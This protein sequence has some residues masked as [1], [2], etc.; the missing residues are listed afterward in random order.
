VPFT[1]L[2]ISVEV[3][4]VGDVKLPDYKKLKVAKK[5]VE[6]TDEDVEAVIASLRQRLAERTDV[7]RAAK[8]GDEVV[9][10]FTGTDAKTKAPI[11]GADGQRYPL[12]LGSDSFIPGFEANL[13]GLK[14][15][16]SKE[17]VLTFPKDYS[18][19]ALQNRK[20]NFGVTA[21]AVKELTLPKVDDAFAAKAGPFK[22][23]RDLKADIRKQLT[24]EKQS[25]A[26]REFENALLEQLAD[27]TTA[28]IPESLITDEIERTLAQVRQNLA[29]RGATWQEYLADMGQ[30]EDEY[31]ASLREPAERRVKVGLALGEVAEAEGI[32]V[33]PEEFQ[34]RLQLLK[35][36]YASDKLMQA[37]LDKPASTRQIISGMLTEKTVAKLTNYAT[38]KQ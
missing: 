8:T 35:G 27:K 29:Y 1:A 36:Q 10:D 2:E 16:E 17:F 21:H 20:V 9:I 5:P 14:P 32:T 11:N 34:L 18:V 4:A 6:I 22:T 28:A 26:D 3:E 30:T 19:K 13:I 25:E 24:A 37:E 38:A 15:G 7:E 31:R 33:T 23:L 12:L